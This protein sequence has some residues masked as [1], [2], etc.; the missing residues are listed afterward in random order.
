[1]EKKYT[2]SFFRETWPE[3]KKK[4]DPLIAQF[5]YRPLSFYISSFCANRGISANSVSYFSILVALGCCLC[6]VFANHKLHIIGALLVNLWLLL[7]CVDGNIARSIRKQPFGKFADAASS[8]FLISFLYLSISFAV[9]Y[10]GGLVVEKSN[11]MIIVLDAVGVV[12]DS[13]MRLLYHQFKKGQEELLRNSDRFEEKKMELQSGDG[14]MPNM[15]ERILEAL[16]IGGYLPLII[17]LCTLL[18][19][20]DLVIFYILIIN[21][22]K[23]IIV[24]FK[25]L[26]NA[27]KMTKEFER[28]ERKDIMAYEL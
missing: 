17:L 10:E 20:A 13:F 18:K 26:S 16:G 14:N 28:R 22:T 12:S 5:F 11:V 6:Y 23:C 9:Y 27:I 15:K 8:L 4:K 2:A 21:V 7:D 1:M 24:T 25:S 3:W 19:T